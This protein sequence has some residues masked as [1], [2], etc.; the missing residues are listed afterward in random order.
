MEQFNFL[1]S[2]NIPLGS[3]LAL[4]FGA[5]AIAA[6]TSD[7]KEALAAEIQ[8]FLVEK[9]F[10]VDVHHDIYA[11]LRKTNDSISLDVLV[12]NFREHWPMRV[13][14]QLS[15]GLFDRE[16]FYEYSITSLEEFKYLLSNNTLV[17]F[18]LNI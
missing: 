15:E 6:P 2:R 12:S 1:L 16:L 9:G 18:T 14:G 8:Q 3:R 7:G 4:D 13:C 17:P 11:K 10:E 5:N